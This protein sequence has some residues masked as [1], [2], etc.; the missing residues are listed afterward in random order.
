[1]AD[2]VVIRCHCGQLAE[3]V[4]LREA[5]PAKGFMCHCNICRHVSGTLTFT[6]IYMSNPPVE[7]FK[8]KLVKYATSEKLWRYFCATCGSQVVYYVVKE[9]RW[10]FCPGA[11]DA[12]KRG[13]HG[14]VDRITAH[15]YVGDTLD[16]G[17]SLCIPDVPY[18]LEDDGQESVKDLQSELKRLQ[19]EAT[20]ELDSEDKLRAECHCGQVSLLIGRPDHG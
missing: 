5:L 14:K 2:E 15:E 10:M 6:G 8:Q 16:G 9:D 13:E 18:Y 1:M 7:T 19:A 20:T 12:V 4:Q 3:T 17:L 11:I